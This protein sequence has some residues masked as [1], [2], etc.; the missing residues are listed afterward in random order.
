VVRVSDG[1]RA[2]DAVSLAALPLPAARYEIRDGDAVLVAANERFASRFDASEPATPLREWWDAN[3]VSAAATDAAVR[4][5]LVDGER[6][7]ATVAVEADAADADAATTYRL[8]AARDGERTRGGLVTLTAGPDATGEVATADGIASVVGHDLRNPL[9]VATAHLQAARETGDPVHFDR[10][11]RAHDRMERIIRDVLTLA[12]GEGTVD[13]TPGVDL[14]AVATDA[15]TTVD[16]GSAALSLAD[17]L[18]TIEADPDRL[19]RLFENLFR[20]GVEHG[21]ANPDAADPSIRIR[22]GAVDDG[23]FVADDGRG[24]APADRE[25]VFEPGYTDADG[26]GL[27]LTIVRRIAAAHGW[28]VS[29]EAGADGGARF[30]VRGLD[31]GAG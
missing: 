31:V 24:V 22:V 7:D 18:P 3:G 6:V 4:S 28:T 26:T 5:P 1:S 12:R 13:P 10:L 8:R 11:E 2:D 30:E 14:D 29:L 25:R 21:P 15:W 23:F 27:G 20:N 17:D 9:D 16:T 19:R